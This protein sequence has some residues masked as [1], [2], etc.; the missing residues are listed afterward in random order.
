[1]TV[2]ADLRQGESKDQIIARLL[3]ENAALKAKPQGDIKVTEKGGVSL[4]GFGK[5]PISLYLSQWEYL[6]SRIE[7]VKAFIEANRDKLAT[8]AE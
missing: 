8:K 2:L 5:W 3:A 6:F 7:D 4:R 1:M